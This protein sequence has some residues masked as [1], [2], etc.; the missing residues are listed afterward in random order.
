M[1]KLNIDPSLIVMFY[2]SSISS[3]LMYAANAFYCQLNKDLAAELA[4]P[5]KA[6][7]KLVPDSKELLSR[8]HAI[9]GKNVKRLASKIIQNNKPSFVLILWNATFVE[10]EG[11]NHPMSHQQV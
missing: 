10:V 11:S 2:T 4:V 7:E 5:L 8:N 9:Y 6:S 3:E 1:K